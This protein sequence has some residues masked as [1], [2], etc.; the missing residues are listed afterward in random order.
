MAG[1]WIFT[2]GAR[3]GLQAARAA[4]DAVA[5]S[6]AALED[7]NGDRALQLAISA[8]ESLCSGEG[9]A[10]FSQVRAAL[11]NAVRRV[12]SQAKAVGRKQA[13]VSNLIIRSR[14]RECLGR[15]HTVVLRGCLG[16]ARREGS[17]MESSRDPRGEADQG[18][19]GTGD[20]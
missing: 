4:L 17:P 5:D 13:E 15:S 12:S 10:A 9:S 18:T 2:A 20:D 7:G 8:M 1:P 6:G 19:E 14:P 3:R 16:R 11:E